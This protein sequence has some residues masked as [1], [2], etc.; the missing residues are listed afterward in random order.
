MSLVNLPP[1]FKTKYPYQLS[2]GEQQRVG[3]CR[4]MLLNPPLFLLDEAF[5][6][7]D[8]TTKNEIHSELQEL[9][10]A[11]SRA[12]VLVTHDPDEALKLADNIMVMEQGVIQQYGTKEEVLKNPANDVVKGFLQKS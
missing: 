2:G 3:I 8:V 12:I 10:K 6:A 5:A 7:L 1:S 4:A 11:E 9:Q